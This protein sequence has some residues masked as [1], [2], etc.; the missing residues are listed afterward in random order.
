MKCPVCNKEHRSIMQ[1][2]SCAVA[3]QNHVEF[4]K[5]TG[6]SPTKKDI[7]NIIRAEYMVKSLFAQ[8]NV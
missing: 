4:L 8:A 1:A 6:I 5:S 7:K 3:L 2:T